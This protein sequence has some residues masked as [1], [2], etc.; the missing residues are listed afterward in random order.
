MHEVE[1]TSIEEADILISQISRSFFLIRF[2]HVRYQLFYM[3]PINAA[4]VRFFSVGF[5]MLQSVHGATA[6]AKWKNFAVSAFGIVKRILC[7]HTLRQ[8]GKVDGFV[9]DVTDTIA[10]ISEL[11]H[12]VIHITFR[13]YIQ[14]K[15]LPEHT[16]PCRLGL[17]AE[18]R[19]LLSR[20]KAG[21]TV[22]EQ[23]FPC[24]T[25]GTCVKTRLVKHMAA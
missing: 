1:D 2:V 22:P 7:E 21:N 16:G 15:G 17:R 5:R 19:I 9:L 23:F 13:I 6:T 4:I 18:P 3:S 8:T 12:A 14:R 24:I 11:F 10:G 25:R 20:F